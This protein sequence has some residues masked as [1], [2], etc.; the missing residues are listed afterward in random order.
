MARAWAL[1]LRVTTRTLDGLTAL[2]GIAVVVLI[3][4]QVVLRFA[5]AQVPP[6]FEELADFL[7]VWWVFLGAALTLRASGHPRITAFLDRF[8]QRLRIEV[9][10]VA[11]CVSFAF[12]FFLT[13][14]GFDLAIVATE[15][16]LALDVPMTYPYLALCAGGALMLLFHVDAMLTRVRLRASTLLVLAVA[17]APA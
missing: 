5:G 10:L 13:K 9:E 14:L 3:F 17:A 12:F 6:A 2:I 4:A 11:D 15:P 16:S 7:F 8:P 1:L